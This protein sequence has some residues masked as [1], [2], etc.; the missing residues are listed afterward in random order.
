MKYMLANEVEYNM[1]AN[2]VEYNMIANEVEYNMIANELNILTWRF[3]GKCHS[4]SKQN[5]HSVCLS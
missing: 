2:E 4:N 1:L 3:L 5:A